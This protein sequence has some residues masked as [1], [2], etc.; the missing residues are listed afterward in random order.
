MYFVDNKE[1]IMSQPYRIFCLCIAL[2]LVA[3]FPSTAYA[4]NARA[5]AVTYY[6]SYSTGNDGNNGLSQAAA[7]KSIDK[8]NALNL[9]PGDSV[10]FKCGDTWRGKMLTI[11]KS[12]AAGSPITFGSYPAGCA[13]KPI[14]SGAQPISDWTLYGGKIY[15][16]ALNAGANAGK[17]GYGVNQLFRGD[18]RLTLGRW[19]NIGAA[20]GGYST[21]DASPA[22]N[23]IS[24]NQ[25]PA[26]NWSGAVAHIRGMRWYILNRKVT[27]RAGQ[28]L[29]L[30]AANDCWGG[31]CTGW[32]YFLNNSLLALDSDGEWYYDNAARKVYLYSTGGAPANGQIEGSVILQNDDRSWGGV[33]LGADLTGQGIAYVTVENLDA[34]RWF[35]SGIAIPTNFANYEPHHLIIRNNA[36]SDA[37]AT[38]INLATW[39][40]SASDGRPDG[41]RGGYGLTVSGNTISRVN[42]M[43]IDLYSRNSTFNGN[44][45]QDVGMIQNLGA[46]GMGCGMDGYGG[47]CTEDG[48]GLRIKVDQAADSGNTNTVQGNRL[49]RIAHN[50]MDIFGH[51]NTIKNNVILQ[52]CAAKGDCGGIRTFGGGNLSTSPV[53]D[54]TFD[55]NIIVDTKGNTDGCRSDFDALFGFGLYIDNY[56]RNVTVTGNTIINSTV[57]GILFQN[58]TGSVTGNTLY[59]NGRTYPYGGAQVY[60]GGSPAAISNHSGNILYSL[61]PNAWTLALDNPALLGTSNNNAFFSPYKAADISASGA[62]TLAQWKTF[63]GKDGASTG[64]WFTLPTGAPVNSTIFY[65]DSSVAKTIDLGAA[66]YKDLNQNP[67]SGSLTLQPYKS[68]ILVLDSPTVVSSKRIDPSP[69]S[70]GTVRFAVAFS[71]P[72]TGVDASDFALAASGVTGA[73]VSGVSGSGASYTVSVATGTGSGAIRLNVVDDDSILDADSNPLGGVGA[74]NGAFSGGEAYIVRPVSQTFFSSGAQDGWVLESSETSNKGGMFNA[75]SLAFQLGDDAQKRQYKAILSFDTS[76]LPDNAVVLSAAL[77]IKQNGAVVGKNP[78]GKFGSLLVDLFKGSFGAPGLSASDFQAAA[79]LKPAGMFGITPSAGWYTAVLGSKAWTVINKA[80]RTEF[81][82]YFTLDDNNDKVADFMRFNSGNAV[83]G[84]PELVIQYI[85]P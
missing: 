16:A 51:T 44:T 27:A 3:S 40:Y 6:V 73:A 45:I 9:Q 41:W 31:D 43:G 36:I 29:T 81:R 78:F 39:V 10:L 74:G 72:V 34:R 53:H 62:K 82:L 47:N 61:N 15:V 18:A 52:A 80:G 42:S 4:A 71:E 76:A 11:V 38:G 33:T 70:L 75:T 66:A 83:S 63:S 28:A 85:V 68:R 48:D 8:V 2:L 50:G 64:N 69:T 12:G 79:S 26:G 59:N 56:S 30:G 49:E 24:D 57:H 23:K 5:G 35:R 25:L 1:I 46:A 37:D 14:L 84:K 65:N 67:V 17:F 22:S 54:L 19:P 58:S 13:N 7:F 32:G 77:R 20:D 60:L 21:I 55:G